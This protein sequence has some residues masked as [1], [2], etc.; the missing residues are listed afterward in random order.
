MKTILVDAVN[1]FLVDGKINIEMKA[2]LDTF[3]HRK[4]IVT[5]ANPDEQ[6]TYG[7]INMPYEMFSLSHSPNKPDPL[8]FKTLLQ[9]Y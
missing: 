1:T 3:P 9:K 7:L 8:Y 5:N 6:I 2:M 4:I